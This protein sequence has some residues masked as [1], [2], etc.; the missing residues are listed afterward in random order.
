MHDDARPLVPTLAWAMAGAAACAWMTP[1]EPNMLEEGIALHLAQRMVGGE[2]LF[3]DLASFTG[4]LPFE[5]LA[6]LFRAFGD[7]IFVARG[8]VAAMHGAATAACFALAYRARGD[9][10]AHVAAAAFAAAPVLLFPLFSLYFY[11]LTALHL[12]MIAAWATARALDDARFALAAGALV[13]LVALCKQNLGAGLAVAFLGCLAFARGA[14]PLARRLAL[15]AAGGASVAAATL[16]L[17]AWRGDLAAL[18]DSLVFLPLSFR[19]T[20]GSAYPNLWPPG[21]LLGDVYVERSRYVP[22][23]YGFRYGVFGRLGATPSLA[24]QALYAAPFAAL[25]LA[26]VA[27]LRRGL[28]PATWVHAALLAALVPGLFPRTD[29]GHL[30][31]VLPAAVVQLCLVARAPA[32]RAQRRALAAALAA[33]LAVA[34]VATGVWLHRAAGPATFGPKLPLRPV[35]EMLKAPALPRVI[36]ALRERAAPGEPIFVARAEPIV[37]YATGTTNPTPYSGVIPGMREE[38]ERVITRALERV[39]FV[40]MSDIDQPLYLYYSDEL[41]GVWAH[42]ERY[43]RVARGAPPGWLTLLER[44]EDRGPTAVDLFDRRASGRAWVREPGAPPA[45]APSPAPRLAAR[46]NRRVLDFWTGADG[47]GVDFEVDVP[48]DAVFQADVG[49]WQTIGLTSEYAHPERTI[50]IAS[51][52]RAGEPEDARVELARAS[53]LDGRHQGRTW[54]PLEA[55]LA[56]FAGARVELRLEVRPQGRIDERHR[57]AWFGSPRI[58]LRPD[59]R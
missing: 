53:L 25:A 3:R 7:G 43:F 30:V 42:L 47:G 24:T 9:A 17:Y 16:A 27:A 14:A 38:Q 33:G 51:L 31:Y 36:R 21:E 45:P 19:D 46:M 12:A 6:L 44:G 15:Y 2:H 49:L 23:L 11:A 32:A 20:F 54:L 48:R 58:A 37:Y 55:D 52:R 50:A 56:A 26:A 8:A 5:L 1:L 59:T 10:L 57:L 29:W 34:V 18:V 22:A 41:P 35:N 39:R 28:A 40:V 4:P 13:A